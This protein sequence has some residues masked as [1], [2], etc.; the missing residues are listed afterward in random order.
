MSI[1]RPIEDDYWPTFCDD[2]DAMVARNAD[3][4]SDPAVYET[5]DSY[6]WGNE[7]HAI[8]ETKYDDIVQ[9]EALPDW[10]ISQNLVV[11]E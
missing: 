7:S 6:A 8:S 11:S 9:D 3:A 1:A 5:I 2:T 10:Y 4:V